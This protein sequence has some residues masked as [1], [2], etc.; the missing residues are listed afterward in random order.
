MVAQREPCP[1]TQKEVWTL[2]WFNKRGCAV[3]PKVLHIKYSRQEWEH[4]PVP[5]GYVAFII[6]EKVPGVPLDDFWTYPREKR[7]KIR[8]AFRKSL[9]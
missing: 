7:D 8:A 5:D 9:T 2:E 3:T 1:W 6:M 4:M